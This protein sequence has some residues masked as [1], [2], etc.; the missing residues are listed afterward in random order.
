K[1]LYL[2]VCT[3]LAHLMPVRWTR[4]IQVVSTPLLV[5]TALVAP[6]AGVA[7]VAWLAGFDRRRPGKEVSWTAFLFNNANGALTYGVPSLALTSIPTFG[8][9]DIPIRTA[10]LTVAI[11]CI[12]YPL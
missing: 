9:Y 3:Q 5:A 10:I 1:L 11:I 4:G 7:L 2:A 8:L 6:G 12:N